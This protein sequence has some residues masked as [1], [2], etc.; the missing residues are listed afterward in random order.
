MRHIFIYDPSHFQEQQWKIDSILDK[1][2]QYFRT[3]ITPKFSTQIP[4]YPRETIGI[5]QKQVDEEK[6][7]ETVRVYAIG[8]EEILFDCLNGIAELS[9]AD[10]AIMPHGSKND[11]LRVFGDDKTELF[12]NISL[13]AESESVPTDIIKAGNVYALNG[14]FVGLAA[15]N[16]QRTK[17]VKKKKTSRFYTFRLFMA[18]LAYLYSIFDRRIITRYYNITVDGEDYSGNYYHIG[19]SN[20]P[21]YDGKKIAAIGAIPDDGLLEVALLKT[22]TPLIGLFSMKKHFRGKTPGNC[23]TMK[24]KNITIKS[25]EPFWVQLDGEFVQDTSI[26]F[27]VA[28][29]A[30]Q[31]V[32]AN[33]SYPKPSV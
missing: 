6:D 12:N 29:K 9:N 23:V 18:F 4:R 8:G 17:E 31:I 2:G 3:Q 13:I 7:G 1:I 33:L 30:V 20:G 15:I 26:S 25:E 5:I 24:A 28:P 16:A 11:F 14:C 22:V 19:V 27:E 10:L 21:R 32:S